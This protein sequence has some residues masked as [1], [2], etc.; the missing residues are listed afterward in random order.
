MYD[1]MECYLY[2]FTYL[3]KVLIMMHDVQQTLPVVPGGDHYDIIQASMFSSPHWDLF[4][5]HFLIDNMRLQRVDDEAEQAQQTAY[6]KMI[7]GIG[8]NEAVKALLIEQNVPDGVPSPTLKQFVLGAIP[9]EN[10]FTL[11]TPPPRLPEPPRQEREEAD[12][13]TP[14]PDTYRVD[15]IPLHSLPAD[16][17]KVKEAMDWLYPTVD[18]EFDPLQAVNNVIL[19]TT[20]R[21]VDQWNERCAARNPATEI[22]LMSEDSFTDVDDD[23]GHLASMISEEV[24]K[25]YS[26]NDVPPHDLK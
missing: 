4:E 2:V 15:P 17:E 18:G 8:L 23:K 16:P 12:P 14:T 7:R 10:I 25:K 6:D 1:L 13:D 26:T 20:N 3:G 11:N 9:K 24:L 5:R 19:A 21:I 22:S